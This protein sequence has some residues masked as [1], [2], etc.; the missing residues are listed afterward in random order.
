MIIEILESFLFACTLGLLPCLYLST[1]LNEYI[2]LN[3]KTLQ[4]LKKSLL[5][6][7]EFTSQKSFGPAKKMFGPAQN[8]FESLKRQGGR[9]IIRNIF[10]VI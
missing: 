6:T 9:K 7:A 3:G 8:N 1:K 2:Q 10:K 5:Y 4:V